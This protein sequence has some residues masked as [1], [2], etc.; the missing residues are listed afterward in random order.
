MQKSP[1]RR[2]LRKS[3]KVESPKREGQ[4]KR[5][6]FLPSFNFNSQ[7]QTPNIKT[8][9]LIVW[10]VLVAAGLGLGMNLYNLQIV[11]GPKLKEKARNQQMVNL[12][13]FVPRRQIIDR[14]RTVLAI[15]RPVYTVY[16]H[17]KLFNKSNQEIAKLLAPIVDKDVTELKNKFDNKKS[18]ILLASAMPEEIANRIF[19]LRLNGLELIQKYSRFYP[20]QDLVAEVVG[21]VN[22]DRRG[23]AGVE[24]S[25]E[26]LLERSVQAVRLSRTGNGSLMPDYAPDGFPYSDDLQLQLTIDSRLQRIARAALKQQM[27]KYSAK[28]G[29]VII[30]DAWDGSL[31]A[32]ASLP[33]Y[34][35]NEYSKADISLFKNWT[36]ADLYEPGSTFKPLNVAIALENG[37]I[38]ANDTF[39]DPGYIQVGDRTIKNA[40]NKS[41]GRINIAQILQHSS[42]IGMVQII[43]R[44]QPSIYYGWLEKLGLGQAVST[45]LPFVVASQLKSQEKFITLP[46]EPATTSFGQGF[47]LTPLQLVQMHGALA[48]GGK[49]VTPHVVK[50]L[51]D[52]KNQM[53]YTP[54]RPAPRQI[55]SSITAQQVVEMMETVVA[56]GSGKAS[57]I[58]GYRIAG[59][60]GTAQKASSSGG[61]ISGARITSFVG[62]L[63]VEAP[64]YVVLA[65]VDEPKGAN[66]Y[67]GTVA[68]PIAKAVM[69]ALI[70]IEQLPPSQA[71]RQ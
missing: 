17:P 57:Q 39:N 8:R 43:Q 42:N 36:V 4:K 29:A 67:G 33:T 55:F 44:L 12:R 45:D 64:R 40:E 10:G 30:M 26:K 14:N 53:H 2:R 28:R 66:A 32:L 23:Q 20:Q 18:G 25:Q 16:A 1:S 41:Y 70:T 24:Y 11:Q 49:L 58:P 56:D 5:R 7:P 65:L 9:L 27:D 60:T 71:I 15:D 19:A 59:K 50:G 31:L 52:S 13:P 37:V 48:N 68:A 46:I 62:I 21:Y 69:E 47:S 3:R 22:L 6:R 61:Y 54:T 38:T 35:P 51:V 34:N 63:P